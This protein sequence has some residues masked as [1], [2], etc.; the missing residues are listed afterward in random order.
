MSANEATIAI[1]VAEAEELMRASLEAVGHSSEEAAIVADH[2][3]DT[4]LRGLKYGGLSRALSIV[5]KLTLE[6]EIRTPIKVAHETP[7]SVRIDGG[8]QVGYLVGYRATQMLI[9]KAATHGIAVASVHNTYFTGM[10][11]YYAEMV[12]RKEL[13]F[14]AAGSSAWHVA[15][16]GSNESRLGTNPIAFGFPTQGVPI[17]SDVAV[18]SCMHSE[19]VYLHRTGQELP[20]GVGYDAAG[21][22]TRDPLAALEGAFTTWGGA[23]GSAISTAVQLLGILAGSV[24][25]PKQEVDC[26]LLMIAIRPDLLIPAGQ[27]QANAREFADRVR[28]ARPV[29]PTMAPRMPFERS[30]RERELNRARNRIEIPRAIHDELRQAARQ[31]AI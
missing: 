1:T 27:L 24:V 21:A 22:P 3:L 23:K 8:A 9:D 10:L 20:E 31:K 17:I 26:A 19:A 5:R 2:L 18:S 7:L 13:V 29:D 25:E 12:T 6:P 15:P 4:E 30:S 16:H 28:A 14:V 11:S